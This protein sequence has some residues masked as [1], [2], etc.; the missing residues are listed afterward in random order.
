MNEHTDIAE[1]FKDQISKN[2]QSNVQ[3]KMDIAKCKQIRKLKKRNDVFAYK[4]LY[5]PNE[6]RGF[7]R[8][9][10]IKDPEHLIARQFMNMK[11]KFGCKQNHFV[12]SK[13]PPTLL[14]VVHLIKKLNSYQDILERKI[15]TK[16]DDLVRK[17][18]ELAHE[19][20]IT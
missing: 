19:N 15:L 12:K 17:N 7:G 9:V 2:Y 10:S 1:E 16:A 6:I 3:C 11:S 14:S 4:F 5:Q 18:K 8:M 20:I 13:K